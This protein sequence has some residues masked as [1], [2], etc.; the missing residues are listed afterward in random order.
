MSGSHSGG[1]VSFGGARTGIPA[2]PAQSVVQGDASVSTRL[3]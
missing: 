1:T 2:A 3:A